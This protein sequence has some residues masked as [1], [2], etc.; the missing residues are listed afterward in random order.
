MLSPLLFFVFVL[1][2]MYWN[3]KF[4]YEERIKKSAALE[5][6]EVRYAKGEITKERFEEMKKDL[7]K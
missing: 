4:R 5:T 2:L 6:L 1:V 7:G 3:Y